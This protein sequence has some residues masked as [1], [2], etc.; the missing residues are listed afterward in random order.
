MVFLNVRNFNILTFLLV[1][2]VCQ[3]GFVVRDQKL[4]NITDLGRRSLL[5]ETSYE[6]QIRNYV[7]STFN[8]PGREGQCGR[9]QV[10]SVLGSECSE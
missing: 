5:N 10:C 1:V 6:L 9:S 7:E 8:I 3:K 4:A 2:R